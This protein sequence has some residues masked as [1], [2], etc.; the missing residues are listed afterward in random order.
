MAII[1][2][3]IYDKIDINCVIIGYIVVS[4]SEP[5]AFLFVSL[6][7]AHKNRLV[8]LGIVNTHVSLSHFY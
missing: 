2:K 6:V 4:E 5:D 8:H 7:E 1:T 3:N